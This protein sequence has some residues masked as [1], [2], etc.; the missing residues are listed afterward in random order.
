MKIKRDFGE[1]FDINRCEQFS[2][3]DEESIVSEWRDNAADEGGQWPCEGLLSKGCIGTKVSKDEETNRHRPVGEKG[4]EIDLNNERFARGR[5]VTG[6]SSSIDL[7][8]MGSDT[9]LAS[10]PEVFELLQQLISRSHL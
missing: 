8:V 6:C 2:F 5:L 3:A 10:S 1:F 7:V 4:K 9:D